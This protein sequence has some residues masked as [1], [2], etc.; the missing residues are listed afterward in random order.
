[1]RA[2]DKA[3]DG[4]A[5][6]LSSMGRTRAFAGSAA[7]QAGLTGMTLFWKV[8]AR[9]R[10]QTL[11]LHYQTPEEPLTRILGRCAFPG[12]FGL[13]MSSVLPLVVLEAVGPAAPLSSGSED[14]RLQSLGLA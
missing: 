5:G 9:R 7:G 14:S 8:Q 3:V 13:A 11:S 12:S 6:V 2:P 10:S 4:L 1:M